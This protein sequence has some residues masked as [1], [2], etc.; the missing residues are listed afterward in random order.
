MI[1]RD[2]INKYQSNAKRQVVMSSPKK[3]VA[4]K[5]AGKDGLADYWDKK[6]YSNLS[7]TIQDSNGMGYKYN[8]IKMNWTINDRNSLYYIV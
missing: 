5:P 8:V 7:E 2:E 3:G 6:R 4:S 1:K